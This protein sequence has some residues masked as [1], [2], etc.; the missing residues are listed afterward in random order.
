VLVGD[1]SC[2]GAAMAVIG[3]TAAA[4]RGRSRC[5]WAEGPKTAVA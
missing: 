4:A 5:W 1:C 3:T 2:A